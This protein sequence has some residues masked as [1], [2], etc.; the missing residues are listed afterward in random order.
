MSNIFT[1]NSCNDK[2]FSYDLVRGASKTSRA[3]GVSSILELAE[4]NSLIPPTPEPDVF[5]KLR[6]ILKEVNVN[7]LHF[8]GHEGEYDFSINDLHFMGVIETT[9]E[10]VVK[11]YHHKYSRRNM[12]VKI[13]RIP[14]SKTEIFDLNSY[15]ELLKKEVTTVKVISYCSN[16]AN[17]YGVSLLDGEILF[18]MELM[19]WSLKEL[20]KKV[21]RNGTIFPEELLGY[22][23]VA[24]LDALIFCKNHGIV[25]FDVKPTT[26]LVNR[27]ILSIIMVW[28]QRVPK[29]F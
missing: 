23:I 10:N 26:I 29:N 20:Y 13:L 14:L 11:K 28:F 3:S 15:V 25:R 19:D 17:F 27:R 6:Q 21:H 9:E 22:V 8:P 2:N 18:C 12:A 7:R 24:S 1:F 16:I 4:A 5:F